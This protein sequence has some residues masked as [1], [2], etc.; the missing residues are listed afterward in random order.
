MKPLNR[1]VPFLPLLGLALILAGLAAYFVTRQ[2]GSTTNIL[3]GLGAVL[4][5]LFVMLR[6][7][8]VRQR[9][10]SRQ[11]RYGLSSL[12]A[13]IFFA[14][15]AI[16]L[17]W[18]AY[19]NR[20]WRWDTTETGEF[21]PLQETVD[22]LA[23]L[24]DPVH[25]IGFFTLQSRGL[26]ETARQTLDSLKAYNPSLSYEFID[27]NSDPL[28]AQEYEI[29][30]DGTL[31]FIK[32][33][34]PEQVVAKSTS[35]T[36]RDIHSALLQVINPVEK[37]AY[38]LTGHGQRGIDD[39]SGPGISNFVSDLN[40]LGF[41]VETLTLSIAGAV[42]ADAD[43]IVLA[44]QQAPLGEVEVSAISDYL[45]R[46]GS[47]FILRDAV[48]SEAR[49][50]AEGDGLIALLEE[51]G[52]I[53][54]PDFIIEPQ[55]GLANQSIP[56]RFVSF[57]F[58]NSPITPNDLESLGMYFQI[59][60]SIG[61]DE[62]SANQLIELVL[63]SDQAWGEVDFETLPPQQGPDDAAGPLAVG[64]S[65]ENLVTGGRIVVF[66]DADFIS[67]DYIFA[68][69]NYLVATNAMNWLARDETTLVLTPRET[70]Q[71]TYNIPQAQLGMLQLVIWFGPPLI[72]ALIGLVVWFSR[73]KNR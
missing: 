17:Y 47:A 71:R 49:I 19:Q 35:T 60:R 3:F 56:I 1:L 43:V 16:M 70:V 36:D 7:D 50:R 67:N 29:E 31:V 53:V 12:L 25:V 8:E 2:F 15:I 66:G 61:F 11:S 38:F 65:V 73:R 37:T 57:D 54:R 64:M 20:D 32:N 9:L 6:P 45:E 62:L 5:L 55:F 21:T 30:S 63:T 68:G 40:G 13:V 26:Q 4:I 59:A 58:G 18:L 34:G 69:G 27:P 52:V 41:V 23:E 14:A 39:Q 33:R 44:D 51:W 72:M 10:S 24:E 42:P 28:L 48:S 22:L 46:G